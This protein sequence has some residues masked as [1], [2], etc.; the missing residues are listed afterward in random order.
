M[1]TDEWV[2]KSTLINKYIDKYGEG[3]LLE[4]IAWQL[5]LKDLEDMFTT[6]DEVESGS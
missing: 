4:H 5:T 1:N 2:E 3:D 6:I